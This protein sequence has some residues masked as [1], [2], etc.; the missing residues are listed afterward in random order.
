MEKEISKEI[1]RRLEDSF[2]RLKVIH[3]LRWKVLGVKEKIKYAAL[4]IEDNELSS[5][6][7]RRICEYIG[8][9]SYVL[10]DLKNNILK[11]LTIQFS[12]NIK[13]N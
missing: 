5:E 9:Y 4:Y 10:F 3:P 6:E 8:G 1:L 13:T 11:E 2:T 12:M 7:K